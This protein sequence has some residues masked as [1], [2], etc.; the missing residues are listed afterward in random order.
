[1]F[2]SFFIQRFFYCSFNSTGGDDFILAEI[3]SV[4]LE[5]E[6]GA[7]SCVDV[8]INNDA[9]FEDV[10]NF[11]VTLSSDENDTSIRTGEVTVSNILIDDRGKG[12]G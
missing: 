3:I 6:A 4:T 8:D 2:I 11:K 12:R 10:E 5:T 7:I 1:M 9:T